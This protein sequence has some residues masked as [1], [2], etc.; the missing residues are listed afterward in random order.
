MYI[1]EL[2][3][4]LWLKFFHE[5]MLKHIYTL[6]S[7]FCIIN[8]GSSNICYELRICKISITNNFTGG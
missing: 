3:G 5:H 2:I 8:L 4:N 6:L 7:I 1:V